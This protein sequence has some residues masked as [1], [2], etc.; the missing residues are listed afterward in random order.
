LDESELANPEKVSP[1]LRCSV[2]QDVFVDPVF[3]S[4]KPCQHTFCKKCIEEW[5]STQQ[6][7]PNCRS[8]L[9][10]CDL[11]PHEAIR[12]FLDELLV[13]CLDGCGWVGR[14]DARPQHLKVCPVT[15][16][17]VELET[18]TAE[19]VCL[20]ALLDEERSAW[21]AESSKLRFRNQELLQ[22][23]AGGS[24]LRAENEELIMKLD[25]AQEELRA[26]G[27][28]QLRAQNQQLLKEL[29]SAQEELRV[30]RDRNLLDA[31]LQ[32]MH[33]PSQEY[34]LDLAAKVLS[35]TLP[36]GGSHPASMKKA[37]RIKE[38]LS[39]VVQRIQPKAA[40]VSAPAVAV[41]EA[42]TSSPQRKSSTDVA[43]I[44]RVQSPAGCTWMSAS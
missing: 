28:N 13:R 6:G 18:Q 16:L 39:Q 34:A 42:M 12:S 5:L 21:A 17:K 20:V 27:E 23:L 37:K 15:T 38:L 41:Q 24:Q 1:T 10:P 44:K 31:S 14:L 9:L 40:E 35:D 29:E 19:N 32:G 43:L 25:A 8:T 26:A 2:C 30:E 36:G 7:C 3:S 11:Q 4:G 33:P 22:E